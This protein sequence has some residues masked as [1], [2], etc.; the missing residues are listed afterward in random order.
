[1]SLVVSNYLN[2]NILKALTAEAAFIVPSAVYV[3][4]YTSNPTQADVGTEVSGGSYARQLVTWAALAA[5]NKTNSASIT[6]PTPT[7]TWGTVTYVALR[8]AIT[9]GN[10]LASVALS[11]P[12][13]I[14]TGTPP[15]T[16][17]INNLTLN[18]LA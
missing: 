12:I 6:F 5:N 11:T 7:G 14:T 18:I 16:V 17:P 4:L 3:A 9:G 2:N 15:L 8:D 10:L 13:A 1:M